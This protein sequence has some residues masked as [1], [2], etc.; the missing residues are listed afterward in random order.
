MAEQQ[1]SIL[2]RHRFWWHLLFWVMTF[3]VYWLTFAG[4]QDRYY[5]E[6]IMNL[7]LLPARMIGTYSLVY[8][9]LPLA[10]EKKKY[11]LFGLLILIHY[12]SYGFILHLTFYLIKPFPEYYKFAS[13]SLFDFPKILTITISNYGIPALAAAIIFFKK[14]HTDT[15][16]NQKLAEEKMAAELSL[17]KSQIHPHFLFNTLNNL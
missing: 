1:L 15:L 8:L 3:V 17:L 16:K 4:Y 6:F 12:V 7:Y 13:Q 2:Y 10:T 11:V 5:E 9:I 14:W